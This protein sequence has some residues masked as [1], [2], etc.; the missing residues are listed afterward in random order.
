MSNGKTCGIYKITNT[1]TNEAYIGKSYNIEK[2]I[3]THKEDLENGTHVNKGLQEDYDL[4]KSLDSDYEIFT[5]EIIKEAEAKDLNKEEMYWINEFNSF[6]R[7]YNRTIGGSHDETH[8]H[9]DYSGGR[10]FTDEKRIKLITKELT[11]DFDNK[12]NY[13]FK[14][15][16][17]EILCSKCGKEFNDEFDFCPYCGTEKPKPKI[18]PKCKLEPSIEFSFCPKCGTELVDKEEYLKQIEEE[19]LRKIKEEEEIEKKKI[20]EHIQLK[21]QGLTYEK[22]GDE[23]FKQYDKEYY[24]LEKFLKAKEI[25]KTLDLEIYD[26]NLLFDLCEKLIKNGDTLFLQGKHIGNFR[27]SGAMDYYIEAKEICKSLDAE[28]FNTDS[29]LTDITKKISRSF[30]YIT[31]N[32]AKEYEKK[33]YKFLLHGFYNSALHYYEKAKA[34]YEN[35]DKD[36]YDAE[37]EIRKCNEKIK[38]LKINI[39]N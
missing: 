30:N 18:C 37:I 8:G 4:A 3:A 5:F 15:T 1:L 35:I 16:S 13:I 17:N 23:L 31:L 29:I 36:S 11:N 2:R 34:T 38:E 24:A 6:E 9:V 26:T 39:R 33:A 19:R 10:L 22:E 25:Y 32:Q 28:V 14:T 21:N 27:S 12:E 20:I 7:G